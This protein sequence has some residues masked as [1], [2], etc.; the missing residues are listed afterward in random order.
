ME[1]RE[2]VK[3]IV[4]SGVV[5]IEGEFICGSGNNQGTPGGGL[6]PGQPGQGGI[7]KGAKENNLWDDEYDFSE[8]DVK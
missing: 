7:L 3:P 4:E 5:K 8:E 1:S 2:Y 6:K